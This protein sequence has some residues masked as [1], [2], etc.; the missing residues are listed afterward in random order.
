MESKI[1]I[2]RKTKRMVCLLV[3]MFLMADLMP[4]TVD[5]SDTGDSVQMNEQFSVS[6]E[7]TDQENINYWENKSMSND[8]EFMEQIIGTDGFGVESYYKMYIVRPE[9]TGFYQLAAQDNA[10]NPSVLD[11][12]LSNTPIILDSNNVKVPNRDAN[13]DN[14]VE[15]NGFSIKHEY[16]LQSGQTY[17][18]IFT[19]TNYE[20]PCGCTATMTYMGTEISGIDYIDK[21]IAWSLT[22]DG[23]LTIKGNTDFYQELGSFWEELADMITSIKIDE[24]I[25]GIAPGGMFLSMNDVQSVEIASTVS[26]IQQ[27]GLS[28]L[29]N[30]KTIIFK[31]N[32]PVFGGSSIAERV[33]QSMGETDYWNEYGAETMADWPEGGVFSGITATAYY[34]ANDSTWTADVRKN[35]GGTITW[36]P[37]DAENVP[38]PTT[39]T[40]SLP[41]SGFYDVPEGS[42]FEE[43][44]KYV[45]GN[46]LMSG[47]DTAIFSPNVVATRG[48]VVTVLY[49]MAGS[50]EVSAN[51]PFSDVKPGSYYENA[52]KWAFQDGIVN[53]SSPTT[54]SPDNNVDRQ[55]LAALLYRSAGYMGYDVS[56]KDTLT[57]FTDAG[58]I[59]SYAEDAL[60]WAVA[61]GIIS[62]T[63]TSTIAPGADATRAQ[64]ATILMR[65]DENIA[66]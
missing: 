21:S 43:A 49:R 35:Y 18:L 36:V 15:N 27:Y 39:P 42:W 19:A 63:T 40:Q 2:K 7:A 16:F 23:V 46:D 4:V 20:V 52:V 30:L 37:Y 26:A 5:A 61:S 11:C 41:T 32:A 51:S 45:S 8:G 25:T 60:S 12:F 59:D 24:G 17:R 50:P 44:V 29:K 64:L 3:V 28:S 62:G 65:F 9:I 54:F 31:G 55:Q 14:G 66:S 6:I 1:S 38:Q 10:S 53:G 47:T 56:A 34:P 13:E 22:A 33:Y 57:S 58:E 48:M